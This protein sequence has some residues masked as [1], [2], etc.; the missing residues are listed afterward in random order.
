M[1]RETD[2]L[3]LLDHI[4]NY[5]KGH[6]KFYNPQLCNKLNKVIVF[7]HHLCPTAYGSGKS[8]PVNTM[9]MFMYWFDF[10]NCMR[11]FWNKHKLHWTAICIEIEV[12]LWCF[13][14]SRQNG[15]RLFA[16]TDHL[17]LTIASWSRLKL[18]IFCSVWLILLNWKSWRGA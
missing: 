18:L 10:S 14:L 9:W 4:T 5:I 16:I 1:N 6:C 11:L 3:C 12:I 13:F 17:T 7:D 15:W 2:H 8:M